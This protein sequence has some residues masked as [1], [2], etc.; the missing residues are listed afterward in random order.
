MTTTFR[1]PLEAALE[2]RLPLEMDDVFLG[3][4]DAQDAR[5]AEQEAEAYVAAV[6]M[7][8]FLARVGGRR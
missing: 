5:D 2:T 1:T 6:E 8:S 3:D 4:H 7:G